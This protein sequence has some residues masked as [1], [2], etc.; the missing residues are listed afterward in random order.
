M[1][2]QRMPS[3][4]LYLAFNYLPESAHLLGHSVRQGLLNDRTDFFLLSLYL[5][6]QLQFF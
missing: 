3:Q 2:E 4:P 5:E 6:F 1:L